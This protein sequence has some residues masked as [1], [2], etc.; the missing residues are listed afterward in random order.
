VLVRETRNPAVSHQLF[1]RRM[2]SKMIRVAK[3][4]FRDRTSQR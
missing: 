1:Q 4:L 3:K 2:I